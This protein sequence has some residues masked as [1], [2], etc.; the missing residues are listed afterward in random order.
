MSSSRKRVVR[1]KSNDLAH[2]AAKLA[3]YLQRWFQV[4]FSESRVAAAT[5]FEQ[6]RGDNTLT[7][8]QDLRDHF[9]TTGKFRA[10][11]YAARRKGF[12]CYPHE[13]RQLAEGMFCNMFV[14]LCYQIAGLEPYVKAADYKDTQLRISDKK[15]VPKDLKSIEK[16]AVKGKAG[17]CD[18]VD[19]AEY[20]RYSA[21]LKE[22]DPTSLAIWPS[23]SPSPAPAAKSSSTGLPLTTGTSP[24]AP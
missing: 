5:V 24:G 9:N 3:A 8:L 4:E 17:S 6:K 14:V 22:H 15:M 13:K 10:I 16:D 1:A 18:S 12:M 21:K 23:P 20:Q 2:A 11:K 7:L 19:F